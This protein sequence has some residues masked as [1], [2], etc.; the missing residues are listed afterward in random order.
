MSAI[1]NGIAISL[2]ALFVVSTLH[3]AR[4]TLRGEVP[5]LM[6]GSLTNGSVRGRLAVTAAGAFELGLVGVLLLRPVHGLAVA[7]LT[8]LVYTWALGR[9]PA[10]APCNCFGAIASTSATDARKRNVAL[11]ALAA[12]GL[13]AGLPGGAEPALL[14]TTSASVAAIILALVAARESLNRSLGQGR[15]PANP[16]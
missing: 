3:K 13:A 14:S 1:S 7:A 10:E 6:A 4:M 16:R 12:A 8:L 11:T 9:L 2:A 5:D 15:V